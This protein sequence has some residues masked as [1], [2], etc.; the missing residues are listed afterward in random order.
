PSIP[1]INDKA[2]VDFRSRVTIGT[3]SLRERQQA[4]DQRNH[5]GVLLYLWDEVRRIAHKGFEDALF[6]D[7]QLLFRM[8]DFF[9]VYFKLLSDV[10]FRVDE[11]LLSD[12]IRRHLILVGVAY[13]Q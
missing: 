8:K 4:I 10:A 11:C 6:Q 7:G 5:P 12:P 13:F 1:D 3:G 9:L 2:F